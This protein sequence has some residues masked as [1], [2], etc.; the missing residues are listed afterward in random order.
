MYKIVQFQDSEIWLGRHVGIVRFWS[1]L[2]FRSSP[3]L[4]NV[5]IW[6]ANHSDN[7]KSSPFRHWM[8]WKGHDLRYRSS[9][10]RAYIL[11]LGFQS[12]ITTFSCFFETEDVFYF[13]LKTFS[14]V[15]VS[16]QKVREDVLTHVD[17][18]ANVVCSFAFTF[19]GLDLTT[20][21]TCFAASLHR[22]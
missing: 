7:T 3:E 8:H 15:C 22:S 20:F 14:L 18:S 19:Q 1:D 9:I 16:Q 13:L 21:F 4:N 10:C 5:W 17:S 11:R 12:Q 2:L 6:V